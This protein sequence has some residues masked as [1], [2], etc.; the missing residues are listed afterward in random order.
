MTFWTPWVIPCS[1]QVVR[2]LKD[3]FPALVLGSQSGSVEGIASSTGDR[4]TSTRC[5]SS[6]TYLAWSKIPAFSSSLQHWVRM[7]IISLQV[8]EMLKLRLSNSSLN[9]LGFPEYK[10][11]CSLHW[12]MSCIEGGTWMCIVPPSLSG[13]SLRGQL[14]SGYDLSFYG[15][16][17]IL[18]NCNLIGE[19]AYG[20]RAQ[21]T[22]SDF[23]SGPMTSGPSL[24]TSGL[25]WTSF[26][27]DLLPELRRS[28][29]GQGDLLLQTLPK[30]LWKS[31]YQILQAYIFSLFWNPGKGL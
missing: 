9:V 3:S 21:A 17:S 28:R 19:G 25:V 26:S 24:L 12:V 13:T 29:E 22:I 4:L 11:N 2:C 16:Q 14:L 6:A 23:P 20:G 30:E 18:P 27:C 10:P 8:R 5:L 31:I 15:E 7:T 1:R